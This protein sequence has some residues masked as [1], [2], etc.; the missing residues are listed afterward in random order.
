MAR[1]Q[2]QR[3]TEAWRL[4]GEIAGQTDPPGVQEAETAYREALV[5]RCDLR[6]RPLVAHCHLGLG[7]LYRRSGGRPKA[8]EYLSTATTMYRQM[9]MGFWLAQAEA[10]LTE[11][12]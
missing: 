7:K 10:A 5:R 1:A 12:G 2:P 6:M 9:K 11:R 8:H 4:L 3:G